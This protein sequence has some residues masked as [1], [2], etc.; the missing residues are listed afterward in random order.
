MLHIGDHDPSGVA[1]FDAKKEDVQALARDLGYVTDWTFTRVA[2]RPEHITE[3]SLAS[4]PP[5]KTDKR[6]T[7][8]DTRTVQA[9]ALPPN[10]LRDLI[11]KAIR[12]RIDWGI[13]EA[14]MREEAEV[15]SRLGPEFQELQRGYGRVRHRLR[16]L[17]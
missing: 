8:V 13:F 5:K 15:R 6:G 1:M 10:I 4:A 2:V 17:G 7:F 3:Y 9:E 14:V 11:H 16:G 12:D